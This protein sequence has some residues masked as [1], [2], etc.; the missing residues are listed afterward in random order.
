M[1]DR[2]PTS[3]PF[4]DVRAEAWA[5]EYDSASAGGHALRERRRR[6]LE[7]LEGATGEL[8]DVGCGSA[9]LAADLQAAGWRYCGVDGSLPMVR[10]ARARPAATGVTRTAVS[11]VLRLPFRDASFDAVICIGVLD[12]V[13]DQTGA[14]RELVRV[15]RP[16]GQVVV[17]FANRHSP[18]AVWS[19]SVFRPLVGRLARLRAGP[20]RG[21][22][23]ASRALL[24]SPRS[25]G[26]VLR[27]AGAEPVRVEHYAH[28]VLPSP[29]DELLPVTAARLAARLEGLRRTRWRWLAIGFLVAA[30]KP[31]AP[32]PPTAE[33]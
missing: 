4:F 33:S 25:A 29:L 8:L 31:K 5:A 11:D 9:V 12:R 26:R 28:F 32:T 21:P 16:G 17:S 7:V 10:A 14:V 3:V 2:V 19:S 15:L 23:L 6:L 27:T 22:D 1:R 13:A 20:G 18:Y 30:Q 24:R